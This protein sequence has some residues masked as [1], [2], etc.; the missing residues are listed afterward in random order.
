MTASNLELFKAAVLQ[1]WNGIVITDA[2]AAA[3]YRV[4]FANPAFCAMTG[5]SAAP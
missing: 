1:S 5:Y 2:D 4:R 3:G